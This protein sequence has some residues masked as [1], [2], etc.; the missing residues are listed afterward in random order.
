[1]PTGNTNIYAKPM[2]HM[3]KVFTAWDKEKYMVGKQ[4]DYLAVRCD[5]MYDIY[6]VE[7]DV[8]GKTY[9]P[10]VPNS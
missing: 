8:F 3:V 2:E 6:I 4:G 9:E 5:D 1:M 7:Q 10:I